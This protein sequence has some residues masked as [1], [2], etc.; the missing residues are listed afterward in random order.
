[1]PYSRS[2]CFFALKRFVAIIVVLVVDFISTSHA[3]ILLFKA[4]KSG[5]FG[6]VGPQARV[7]IELAFWLGFTQLYM[8]LIGKVWHVG[9]YL[10]D[11]LAALEDLQRQRLLYFA[12]VIVDMHRYM[13]NRDMIYMTESLPVA[14]V[15]I[16]KDFV[17]D[18]YYFGISA[19]PALQSFALLNIPTWKLLLGTNEARVASSRT[20]E[21]FIFLLGLVAKFLEL[22]R[23]ITCVFTW[24]IDC[25]YPKNTTSSSYRFAETHVKLVNVPVE[26]GPEF[27]AWAQR[28]ARERT[29]N[30]SVLQH[31]GQ[32]KKTQSFDYVLACDAVEKSAGRWRKVW[33][34]FQDP[35]RFSFYP[36]MTVQIGGIMFCQYQARITIKLASSIMLLLTGMLIRLTPSKDVLNRVQRLRNGLQQGPCF[37]SISSKWLWSSSCKMAMKRSWHTGSRGLLDCSM[38]PHSWLC[39]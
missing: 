5:D 35:G 24:T 14:L 34:G 22:P 11:S 36:L 33:Q 17:Y 10:F 15:M 21:R 31:S 25:G 3:L 12:T 6:V 9:L 30:L 37:S 2:E 13:Y 39:C 28:Q 18:V 32:S 1:M 19:S 20:Y 38:S 27:Q 16:F 26:F 23:R 4:V 7:L 8:L 29:Q